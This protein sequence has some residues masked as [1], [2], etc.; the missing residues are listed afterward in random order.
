MILYNV[1]NFQLRK[2][3]ENLQLFLYLY[4]VFMVTTK[5]KTKTN[6]GSLERWPRKL[7]L[8]SRWNGPIGVHTLFDRGYQRGVIS[9]ARDFTVTWDWDF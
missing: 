3:L 7:M 9:V 8:Q 5:S 1:L 6:E 4:F 2:M